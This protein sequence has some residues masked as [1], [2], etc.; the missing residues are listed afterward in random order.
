ML[1]R[2]F[3][4]PR[5]NW[6]RI[7]LLVFAVVFLLAVLTVSHKRPSSSF[8]PFKIFARYDATSSA[9]I[10]SPPKNL[11]LIVQGEGDLDIDPQNPG[12]T[13]NPKYRIEHNPDGLVIHAVTLNIPDKELVSMWHSPVSVTHSPEGIKVDY[14]L[15]ARLSSI[16]GVYMLKDNVVM[17]HYYQETQICFVLLVIAGMLIVYVVGKIVLWVVNN[18]L[19][20]MRS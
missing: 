16:H 7:C 11:R 12:Q 6:G 13:Q 2:L 4:E 9:V 20:R 15:D 8:G 19:H 17:Q 14:D 18:K 3:S 5:K 10:K 1:K